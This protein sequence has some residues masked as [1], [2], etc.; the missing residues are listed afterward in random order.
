M[1]ERVE[2][3]AKPELLLWGRRA[4][5]FDVETAAKKVSVSQERLESW[6]AGLANPTIKQLR[7]LANAY[8]RPIAAF[9]LP[10]A[11]RIPD[12]PRDFRRT[13]GH[14]AIVES[15]GLRIEVRKAV[16]RRKAALELLAL[17]DKEPQRLGFTL[18]RDLQPETAGEQ[19]RDLLGVQL[20]TQFQWQSQY[21]ALNGWR[22]AIERIGVLVTQMQDV[23]PA[24]AS[25][26]SVAEL[27]LP[28]IV[29]NI[30][31][32]PRRRVFTLLH[33][34]VHILLREGGLCDLD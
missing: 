16:L 32:S 31:D 8:K 28:V 29:A 20:K 11:P 22:D 13:L 27:P 30:K 23:P 7:T 24:E 34:L 18:R 21:D 2:A 3:L 15:P 4:A 9:F 10:Q 33:E 6:E 25:G 12:P 5:G 14:E 19:V 1:A 17:E 26:F